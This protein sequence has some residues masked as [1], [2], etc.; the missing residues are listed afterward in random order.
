LKNAFITCFLII[1]I[2][3]SNVFA[4]EKLVFL[5]AE[6][7]PYEYR[8]GQE[9]KGLS[10]ELLQ[11]IFILLNN[12]R[13]DIKL[14][15]WKRAYETALTQKNTIV[16]STLRTQEREKLFYWIGPIYVDSF[17]L[18]KLKKRHD[19]VINTLEDAKKYKVG[20]VNGTASEKILISKGFTKHN[21]ISSM[22][23]T[24][25][26]VK[27]LLFGRVDLIVSSESRLAFALKDKGQSA[28]KVSNAYTIDNK[29]IGYF[30]FN[31]N[32][33]QDTIQKFKQA[34]DTLVK[35]G[36]YQRLLSKYQNKNIAIK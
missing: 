16:F 24:S 33:E 10:I 23:H 11:E 9:L 1:V 21:H 25:Q 2:S 5:G 17:G 34:Y 30:A 31:I 19:I 13:N 27:M 36:T 20:T 26:N 28:S 14:I 18:F 12:P 32:T 7:P 29:N 15:P 4:A 35:N 8:E 3:L 6:Y 22:T